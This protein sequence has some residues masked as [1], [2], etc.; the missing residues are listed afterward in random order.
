MPA[1]RGDAILHSNKLANLTALV[2]LRL[3]GNRLTGPLPGDALG[4]L[5]ALQG[6]RLDNNALSGPL[7]P[8][9]GP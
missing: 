9:V 3:D 5:R 1:R 2:G 7:P 8:E 6:L 4:A